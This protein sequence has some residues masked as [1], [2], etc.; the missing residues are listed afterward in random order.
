MRN[1][2]T[3]SGRACVWKPIRYGFSIIF[4]RVHWLKVVF[5]AHEKLTKVSLQRKGKIHS[6]YNRGKTTVLQIPV[7]IDIITT[8]LRMSIDNLKNCLFFFYYIL[9]ISFLSLNK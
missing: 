2:T 3:F 9:N 7:L 4:G 5:E 6:K 8:Y 1:F